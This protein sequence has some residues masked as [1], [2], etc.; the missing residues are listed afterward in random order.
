MTTT[1]R[2]TPAQRRGKIACTLGPATA[3]RIP[4]LVATGMDVARLNFSHGDQ[5]DHE[6]VYRAVRDAAAAAGRAVAVLADLQGPKIRLGRFT[7]GPVEW[8]AGETVRITVDDVPGTHDR[9]STTYGALAADA[10]PGDRLLVDDGRVGLEVVDVEGPDVVC[11]VTVGGTVSDNKGLS[12]PGMNV[13]VPA[14]SEKDVAD[15]EFA[16]ALG[17]NWVA[18]S[19]VRSPANAV[20]DGADA[21]MLSGETSVGAYPIDTVETMARIIEEAESDRSGL[22]PALRQVDR[23]QPGLLAQAALGIADGL[24]AAALV[25]FTLSGNTVRRLARLHPREPLVALTPVSGVRD[26]LASSWG[27][28]AVLVPDVGSAEDMVRVV[29]ET[30]LAMDGF[31]RGDVVVVVAGAPPHTIG[32]TDLLRV[33]RLGEDT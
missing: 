21:V 15:L 26:Q 32:L 25:A 9:V 14:L 17:V 3:D 7:N 1:R 4:E 24:D 31:T 6:K 16:L 2:P 12:L 33:H 28:T 13:S 29:D 8:R 19:F 27:T 5:A 10:K 20:L 23:T 22:V 30:L 11:T 18:L